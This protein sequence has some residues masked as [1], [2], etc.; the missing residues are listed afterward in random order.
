MLYV[1]GMLQI[2]LKEVGKAFLRDIMLQAAALVSV[3]VLWSCEGMIFLAWSCKV[4][5]SRLTWVALVTC[6]AVEAG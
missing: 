5:F 3:G 1:L 6:C 2:V 4:W